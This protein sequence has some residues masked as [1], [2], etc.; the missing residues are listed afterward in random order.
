M[1]RAR[2]AVEREQEEG[3]S[4]LPRN[5]I[6]LLAATALALTMFFA[7]DAFLSGMQRVMHRLEQQEQQELRRREQE[8]AE[9][10]RKEPMPAYVVP[11][12]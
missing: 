7:F 12:E 9:R 8:E 1:D 10:K 4:R 2:R 11:S 3:P 6:A 5:L